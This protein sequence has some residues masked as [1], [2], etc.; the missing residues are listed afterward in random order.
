[1]FMEETTKPYKKSIRF[2]NNREVRVVLDDD[3]NCWLFSATD[4]VLAINNELDYT[5]AGNYWR[6]LKRK[7][8]Q[9][10][11]QLVSATHGFKFDF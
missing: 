7:L 3:N 8:S 10:G 4:I 6:W 9:E 11:I 1:M 2:F 5:K